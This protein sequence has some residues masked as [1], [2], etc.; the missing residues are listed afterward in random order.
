MTGQLAT[1]YGYKSSVD[2]SVRTFIIIIALCKNNLRCLSL[3]PGLDGEARLS[4]ESKQHQ[5]E[6]KFQAQTIWLGVQT[7]P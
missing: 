4:S 7:G 5:Q 3:E 2:L 6:A 1:Y